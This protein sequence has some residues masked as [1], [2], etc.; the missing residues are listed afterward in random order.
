MPE[1]DNRLSVLRHGTWTLV[2]GL[3]W[4]LLE[5][6]RGARPLARRY[7]ADKFVTVFAG[8]HRVGVGMA[9]MQAAAVSASAARKSASL[10]L[11]VLPAL[12]AN[13]WGI[14]KLAEGKFW[15]VAAQEG[16]LSR[17][18]DVI[19]D[20]EGIRRAL[21]TFLRF[22]VPPSEARLI[23]CPAGFL[24]SPTGVDQPLDSL[25]A[26]LTV[27]RRARLRSVSTRV[28]FVSW[29][30]VLGVVL[31]SY[32][33]GS[34]YQA[35][36]ENQRITAARE[37]F[38]AAK[39]QMKTALP[40]ALQ[41]WKAEPV[42]AEFLATCTRLWQTAPLSIAGWRFSTADCHQDALRLAWNKP[43]GGTVGDFSQ[44]LAQWYPQ[45]SALFN[46]PGEADTGGVALPLHMSLP[47]RPEAVADSDTQTQ[48]LTHYA[49]LL[50][51]QL[52]LTEEPASSTPINGQAIPLPWRRF[53]FTFKTAIPPDRLFSPRQF[54]ATGVRIK[55]IT[56]S[57]S[58]ARLHYVIEGHL[59][60]Q[61]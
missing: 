61:R 35:W 2:A 58:Q 20:P 57:L 46:I 43:Q 44:R 34:Q 39:Q 56:V 38:L 13:G 42:L 41:P 25:L 1:N 50:R 28:A 22:D 31:G 15:F 4:E 11:T 54:D 59:Y 37:A 60:A 23:F 40:P 33:G 10:A 48:R 24:P 5:G 7:D 55:R 36:L 8:H 3:H 12:G 21:A 51:A 17:L 16:R 14:F 19:G 18:S 29:V 30:A 53:N 27:P 52:S 26:T 45:A 49:Q 47:A 9:N 32:W 6:R